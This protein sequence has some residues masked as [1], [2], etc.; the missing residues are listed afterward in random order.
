MIIEVLNYSDN[1]DSTLGLININQ[2]FECYALQDEGRKV[3][4]PGET[5]V[6]DGIYLLSTRQVLSPM[7]KRYRQSFD[8]FDWHLELQDV[9]DFK[10]CYFHYGNK[11]DHTDGCILTG[12]SANNNQAGKGWIGNS[13]Q[14]FRRFYQ[15][16]RPAI[17]R[18]KVFVHIQSIN[19]KSC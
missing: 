2:A 19:Q 7:T 14:A 15:K 18:E 10:H 5:R 9:P 1:G 11:E 6:P 16:V 17:D 8:W 4:V 13:I 3:K 12:D